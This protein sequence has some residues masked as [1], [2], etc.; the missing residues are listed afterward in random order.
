[1]MILS[2]VAEG[3][4]VSQFLLFG[5]GPTLAAS[6]VSGVLA[7]PKIRLV[8]ANNGAVVSSNDNWKNHPSAGLTAQFLTQQGL[9]ISDLDAAM[10]LDLGAGR[11]S[12]V[13]EGADGGTGVALGGVQKVLL[14]TGGITP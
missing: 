14:A 9:T 12:L 4:G 2:F 6:G 1:V 5:I 11:Y 10:V 7:D 3:A 8:N 13:V